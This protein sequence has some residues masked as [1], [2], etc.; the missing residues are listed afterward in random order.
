MNH[1]SLEYLKCSCGDYLAHTQWKY[2]N[3]K[4]KQE[5]GYM[6]VYD[7]ERWPEGVAKYIIRN[8]L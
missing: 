5:D 2:P 3:K 4:W 6:L 8:D 7:S 1:T